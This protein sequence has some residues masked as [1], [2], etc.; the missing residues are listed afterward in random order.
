MITKIDNQW[1][2]Q[3]EQYTIPKSIS[4]DFSSSFGNPEHKKYLFFFSSFF[5][6]VLIFDEAELLY[7]IHM[8]LSLLC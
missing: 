1:F 3:A 4:I 5:I 2:H 8:P 7:I 6:S